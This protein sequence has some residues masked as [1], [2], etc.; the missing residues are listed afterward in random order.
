MIK[1]TMTGDR[2]ITKIEAEGFA[3]TLNGRT[4]QEYK[5]ALAPLG[6]ELVFVEEPP[7]M[8]IEEALAT[9][10]DAAPMPLT[11]EVIGD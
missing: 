11:H 5:A 9:Q 10:R 6:V 2:R 8:N 3:I 1:L 4:N 7:S